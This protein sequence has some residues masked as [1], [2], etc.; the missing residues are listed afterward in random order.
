VGRQHARDLTGLRGL[1]GE[2]I[3]I[4]AADRDLHSGYFGGAAAN[5]IH[6][7]SKILADMHDADGG[8]DPEFL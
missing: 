8:D 6:I 4:Q 5:P 2:E 3:T 1:V 7:L